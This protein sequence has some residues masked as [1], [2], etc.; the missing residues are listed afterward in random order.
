MKSLLMVKDGCFRKMCYAARI[1]LGQRWLSLEWFLWLACSV[2]PV[3]G[4]QIVGMTGQK[5]GILTPHTSSNGYTTEPKGESEKMLDKIVII[6][7]MMMM[8]MMI[9]NCQHCSAYRPF[10]K[11]AA[12]D[13]NEL[14]LNSI[15]N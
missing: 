14:K 11:M 2:S 4:D 9:N 1:F 7:M 10:S 3:N 6:L 12:T 5:E 15:K 8:M 13:L